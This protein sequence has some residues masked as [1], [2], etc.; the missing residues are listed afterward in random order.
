MLILL[1]TFFLSKFFRNGEG[2]EA[3]ILVDDT[4]DVK[5]LGYSGQQKIVQDSN[6]NFFVTYRKKYQGRYEIFVAR[7]Y[8][9]DQNWKVSGTEKPVA[10]V[11]S[12]ADQRVP[13]INIG[14]DGVLYVVWYG[15]DANEKNQVNNRQIKFVK[16]ADRGNTWSSAKNISHVDGYESSQ[17]YWQEHPYILVGK[18]NNLYVTWEGK[19]R[20]NS[21]QQIKFS[22]STDGGESWSDWKNISPA[23]D[24]TQSRPTLV[25]DSSKRLHLFFYSSQLNQQDNQQINYSW[26]DDGGDSW[27]PFVALSP[28]DVDARH[29]TAA[30]ISDS[31]HIAWRQWDLKG[32][33]RIMYK[34]LSKGNWQ[35][36]E[37]VSND[38]ENQFFPSISAGSVGNV[39]IGWMETE[40]SF[41][42]PREDPDSGKIYAAVLRGNSFGK[43]IKI[44]TDGENL[45]ANFPQNN[46][47]KHFTPLIFESAASSAGGYSIIFKYLKL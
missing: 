17:A 15:S 11:G 33:A 37:I 44:A 35:A 25:I 34:K 16:S 2:A 5:G 41:S 4:D 23:K 45:Y 42:L 8:L 29:V 36:A 32:E 30:G 21:N 3:T 10:L 20:E 18:N 39:V 43:R 19:D 13:S 9:K 47:N 7:I 12:K 38:G 31:V 24:N 1:A 27:S 14:T 28:E 26:S 6:G 46:E 22:K 40:D